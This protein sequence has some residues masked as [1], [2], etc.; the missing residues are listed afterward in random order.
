MFTRRERG[1]GARKHPRPSHSWREAAGRHPRA[2]RSSGNSPVCVELRGGWDTGTVRRE[3][4]PSDWKDR[5]ARRRSLPA[6]GEPLC[7]R[8]RPAVGRC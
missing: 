2:V 6:T 4:S 3:L 1:Q 8:R 7:A 5:E